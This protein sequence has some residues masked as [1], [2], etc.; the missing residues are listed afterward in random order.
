[1]E[2]VQ[3]EERRSLGEEE[4]QAGGPTYLLPPNSEGN[5]AEDDK[6][7]S[8]RP[9]ST[10]KPLVHRL[11]TPPTHTCTRPATTQVFA[12]RHFYVGRSHLQHFTGAGL[13]LLPPSLPQ[14]PSTGSVEGRLLRLAQ[15]LCS[16]LYVTRA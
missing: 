15:E 5:D 13:V 3:Q 7:V 1:M 11:Q 6:L 14:K 9:T 4:Q 2:P 10:H 8:A 16:F 12:G